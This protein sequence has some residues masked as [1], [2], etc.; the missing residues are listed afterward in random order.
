MA[1]RAAASQKIA[2]LMI[3]IT[4]SLVYITKRKTSANYS[5]FCVI[6]P[7]IV[8]TNYFLGKY[9]FYKGIR[10]MIIFR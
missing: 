5:V 1:L 7:S 10:V 4:F 2:G 8:Y 3:F 6:K 9:H